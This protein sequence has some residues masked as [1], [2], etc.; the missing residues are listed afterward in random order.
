MK[1]EAAPRRALRFNFIDALFLL[2]ILAASA[3]LVYILFF[4]NPENIDQK[5]YTDVEYKIELRMVREELKGKINIGDKVIDASKLYT[6][7]EVTDVKYANAIYTGV[8]RQQGTLVYSEYPGFVNITVTIK[9]PADLRSGNYMINGV[10]K[11]SVGSYVS[12]R[13]PNF[14][15]SGYCISIKEV[16]A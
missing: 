2:I 11:L 5:S 10:Y 3:L 12:I 7:G 1:R 14:T 15:G 4:H 16:T 13:V 6:I 9:A 8:N